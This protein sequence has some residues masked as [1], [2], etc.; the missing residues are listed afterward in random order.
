MTAPLPAWP[1]R[2][3]FAKILRRDLAA[4]RRDPKSQLVLVLLRVCQVAMGSPDR[5][6]PVAYP[7]IAFYRL[8]TE[9]FLGME[10]RPKTRIGA[11]LSIYHGYGLVL[12]DHCVIGEDVVLRNGVTIGNKREG[13]GVP[14]LGNRVEVGAGAIILGDISIGSDC[15]VGAGSVVLK[16]FPDGSTLVGNPARL[17]EA[18]AS[19]DGNYKLGPGSPAA[20]LD[21]G[22]KESL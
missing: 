4:N 7:L 8:F 13:G 17:L 2:N 12:N 1:D 15:K 5:V 10:V 3:N 9:F 6:R 14:V 18:R 20:G 21:S 11:G 22:T 19:K 16:S